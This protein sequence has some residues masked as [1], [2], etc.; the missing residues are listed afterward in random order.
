LLTYPKAALQT[1]SAGPIQALTEPSETLLT[2]LSGLRIP[3]AAVTTH[4]FCIGVLNQA[5]RVLIQNLQKL[6]HLLKLNQKV[7]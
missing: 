5:L 6:N 2:L 3:A 4:G 1:S 7:T